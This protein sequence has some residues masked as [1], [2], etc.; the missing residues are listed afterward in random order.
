M[1]LEIMYPIQYLVYITTV[2]SKI[3]FY[4]HVSLN[5]VTST[6]CTS[7]DIGISENLELVDKFCYLGNMLSVQGA[8]KKVIPCHFLL[9]SQ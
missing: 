8:S 1:F 5:P 6:G 2:H 4:M 3:N 9:I 7:V